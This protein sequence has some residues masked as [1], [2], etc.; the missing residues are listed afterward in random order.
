[1]KPK[2]KV[3]I[4]DDDKDF[5][6]SLKYFFADNNFELFLAYTLSD[7]MI[8]LE[9]ERPDHIFLDNRLPDGSGWEKTEYILANYPQSHLNLLSA[10]AVPKTSSSSFRIFEKPITLEEILSCLK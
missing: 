6:L 9:K 4:I 3:L 1:M 7:G 2:K 5:G 10:L 8:M